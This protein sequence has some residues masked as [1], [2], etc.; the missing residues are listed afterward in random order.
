MNLFDKPNEEDLEDLPIQELADLA[1]VD[2]YW[3]YQRCEL[4]EMVIQKHEDHDYEDIAPKNKQETTI[5]EDEPPVYKQDEQFED[6]ENIDLK[7]PKEPVC[8]NVEV[9]VQVPSEPTTTEYVPEDYTNSTELETNEVPAPSPII[10]KEPVEQK[11]EKDTAD[12]ILTLTHEH[13]KMIES[14]VMD[15]VKKKCKVK[16]PPNQMLID[17]IDKYGVS[18]ATVGRVVGVSGNLV[19]TW[20]SGKSKTPNKHNQTIQQIY[21]TA[22]HQYEILTSDDYANPVEGQVF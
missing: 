20:K 10:V 17:I 5:K 15:Y 12:K 9:E 19:L 11:K 16:F 1:G 18:G 8:D 21:K 22:Q 4:I 6:D 3:E 14:N 2:S 13:I 7:I